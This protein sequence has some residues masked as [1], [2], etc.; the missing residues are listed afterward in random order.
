MNSVEARYRTEKEWQ[1]WGGFFAESL[2]LTIRKDVR[3]ESGK[4]VTYY[5]TGIDFTTKKHDVVRLAHEEFG[6]IVRTKSK[7]KGQNYLS[8]SNNDSAS[9]LYFL[10]QLEP[11]L[12]YNN[13]LAEIMIKFLSARTQRKEDK[14]KDEEERTEADVKSY[15]DL[16][17]AKM[18]PLDHKN[19]LPQKPTLA[20]MMDSNGLLNIDERGVLYPPEAFLFLRHHGI[21]QAINDNYG[22]RY[23][24]REDKNIHYWEGTSGSAI[25]FVSDI[26][27]D[28]KLL[29]PQAE[30]ML[31]FASTQPHLNRSGRLPELAFIL[32][33]YSTSTTDLVQLLR[34][35]FHA[36]M[37]ALN[38]K[39]EAS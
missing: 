22:G 37:A 11:Y 10:E 27:D 17:E 38:A 35:G 31:D 5:K 6:G 3:N 12:P 2:S 30:T 9:A 20:G 1:Y 32:G 19:W 21:L 24:S 18:Q 4:L 23:R 25:R 26:Y 14:I 8:W 28:L 16:K 15:N 13:H 7:H 29:Q 36:K 34:L 33:K 39:R